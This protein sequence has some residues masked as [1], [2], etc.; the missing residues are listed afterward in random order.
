M[1][2]AEMMEEINQCIRTQ[3]ARARYTQT[4]KRMETK[5]WVETQCR[6][7]DPYIRLSG[8]VT[9]PQIVV[10][11]PDGETRWLED[12]NNYECVNAHENF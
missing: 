3:A 11:T 10:T 8:Q 5:V 9:V 2:K 6:P 12:R 1:S 4:A 7:R